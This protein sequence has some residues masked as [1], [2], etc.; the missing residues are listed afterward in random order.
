MRPP[1]HVVLVLLSA[2]RRVPAAHNHDAE[3]RMLGPQPQARLELGA[4]ELGLDD[5]TPLGE[6]GKEAVHEGFPG[7]VGVDELLLREERHRGR[8]APPAAR[9]AVAPA[10]A[11]AERGVLRLAANYTELAAAPAAI[12]LTGAGHDI[13]AEPGEYGGG[14][15]DNATKEDGRLIDHRLEAG[16]LDDVV[17]HAR[18][19]LPFGDS[20]I[21]MIDDAI[22]EPATLTILSDR[23]EALVIALASMFVNSPVREM[24]VWLIGNLERAKENSE[25]GNT[26]LYDRLYNA[27][28]PPKHQRL[29]VMDIDVVTALLQQY[30]QEPLWT[31]PLS[32]TMGGDQDE[33]HQPE[34][35]LKP[36]DW[37]YDNMHHD[38]FNMLRFY[39]PYLE[40]FRNITTLFFADDDI[41]VTKDLGVLEVPMGDGVVIAAT[42]NGWLWDEDC[43]FSKLFYNKRDWFGF[44]VSYLGRDQKNNWKGCTDPSLKIPC[45]S[46]EY[47][48]VTYRLS[49]DILGYTVNYTEQ[50]VWNFG[51]ARFNMTEWRLAKMTEVFEAFMAANYKEKIWPETSLSYGLGISYFAFASRIRCWNDMVG[52]PAFV[53]GLGYITMADVESNQIT[54]TQVLDPAV[55]L[56]WSGRVKPFSKVSTLEMPLAKPFDD[57]WDYIHEHNNVP[58]LDEVITAPRALRKSVS[59]SPGQSCTRTRGRVQNG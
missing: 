6:H 47:E 46:D 49:K 50:P 18:Q 11:L 57:M 9:G 10:R 4:R 1:L 26:S 22:H 2:A 5:S 30:G 44:S 17:F 59:T 31:W 28:Q 25:D 53:D 14:V 20:D 52:D 15:S 55:V 43:L 45:Q 27:L 48:D 19:K 54:M 42:C 3:L 58:P 38:P 21:H 16:H 51:L 8:H 56:H 36:E 12:E 33:D 41:M 40:P 23:Y 29:H 35:L 7:A 32:G 34:L 37:D 24:D 13:K 39:L